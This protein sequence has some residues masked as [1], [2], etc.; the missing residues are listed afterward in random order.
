MFYCSPSL[1][2][3]GKHK[4]RADVR[5]IVYEGKMSAL[6]RSLCRFDACGKRP[7]EKLYLSTCAP[8]A[9]SLSLSLSLS[10]RVYRVYTR[11]YIRATRVFRICNK[12]NIAKA[13]EFHKTGAR[14]RE[15]PV[16]VNNDD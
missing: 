11:G 6:E 5:I 16:M 7:L 8:P 15:S 9:F 1:L 12:K 13:V 2:S 4:R 10:Y 3:G 14:H